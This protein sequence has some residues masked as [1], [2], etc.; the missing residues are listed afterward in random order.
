MNLPAFADDVLQIDIDTTT[1]RQA[2]IESGRGFASCFTDL[3]GLKRTLDDVG[4]R[5]IFAPRKSMSKV[6]C[7]GAAY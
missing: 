7:L 2:S 5:A 4:Y 3:I 6:P 1:C